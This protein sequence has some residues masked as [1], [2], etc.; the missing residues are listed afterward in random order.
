MKEFI[1][2]WDD[3]IRQWAK[4][5]GSV[6]SV[7]IS[8]RCWFFEG[9]NLHSAIMPGPYS[10][11]PRKCSAV[12][13]NY[14]PGGPKVEPG[15]KDL[16]EKLKDDG[17]IITHVKTGN[18]ERLSG[19]IYESFSSFTLPYPWHDDD[20]VE[21]LNEKPAARWINRLDKWSRNLI[22]ND[23]S[24]PPFLM[25]ICA[26]HSYRWQIGEFS[27]EQKEYI[28]T[29]VLPYLKKAIKN[30]QL[31]IGLSVGKIL[32]DK[33][34]AQLGFRDIT[35]TLDMK[36]SVTKYGWQPIEGINR[37]YRVY[38]D[39]DGTTII[40][41]WSKGSNRQPSVRFVPYERELISKLK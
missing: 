40:N 5:D 3:V 30:S 23:E 13:L 21:R 35:A 32:G 29:R 36:G 24:Y 25:D 20:M 1:E 9:S 28:S 8:E 7:P 26:W 39:E 11:D 16:L 27:P 15:D 19:L 17:S 4:G 37:W 33:A 12:V 6:E 2:Y 38:R 18:R 22:D 14:N 34:F 10:G 31:G 41:T